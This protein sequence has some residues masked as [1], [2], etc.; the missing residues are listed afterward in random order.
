[1]LLDVSMRPVREEGVQ[2]TLV[3]TCYRISM[4]FLATPLDKLPSLVY[5]VK[6]LELKATSF[7]LVPVTVYIKI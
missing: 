5:N 7:K 1:M 3:A 4:I 2:Q 6:A